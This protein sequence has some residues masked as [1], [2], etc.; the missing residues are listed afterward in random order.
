MTNLNRRISII[1]R[2]PSGWHVEQL[3]SAAE[4]RNIDCELTNLDPNQPLADQIKSLGDVIIY[5]ASSLDLFSERASVL[6]YLRG[7]YMINEGTFTAPY[8]PY[9]Y[10]QQNVLAGTSYTEEYSIP[11]YRAHTK[12]ALE[13]YVSDQSLKLPFIAK[14]NKGAQGKGIE[15]IRTSEDL[16]TFIT[17]QEVSDYVY[18]NFIRND[19]DWRIIV[20]GGR[21]LG[22]VKR[23]PQKEDVF[24]NNLS[25][26]ALATNETDPEALEQINKIAVKAASAMNLRYCGVD[27]I[28]DLDTGKYYVLETNTAP[29]WAVPQE[30]G[31]YFQD[32]TGVDVAEE[33]ID[34]SINFLDRANTSAHQL[35]EDYYK[36]GIGFDSE[37]TFHFASRM[38][39]WSNDEWAR[40]AL[41]DARQQ[42]IGTSGEETGS[43]IDEMVQKFNTGGMTLSNSKKF[44]E[45]HFNKFPRIPLYNRLFFKMMFADSIYSTDIRPQIRKHITDEELL[46]TFRQLRADHDAIRVLS[47]HAINFFYLLKYYFRDNTDMLEKIQI[48]PDEFIAISRE[49]NDELDKYTAQK[50]RI[51]LLTHVIIGESQF[52][53]RR[54]ADEKYAPIIRELEQII[55][56]DFSGTSL[57]NKNEFLVC[58]KI[59]G[60]ET[61]LESIIL[62]ESA[63]SLS[64]AGNF[65]VESNDWGDKNILHSLS[66]AEHRNVLFIMANKDFKA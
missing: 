34:Y 62:D 28:R 24:L 5:R 7:K 31:T 12:E 17:E 55:R 54:L 32:A 61:S 60:V 8:T 1:S 11:T 36:H 26:G 6:P 56:D 21:P 47:T 13:A 57:D 51:Y 16:Q 49:Y 48:N 9:K 3:K 29:Q 66:Q 22:V 14:P 40:Q 20:V 45:Q 64:W 39:L 33:L 59:C 30:A 15:L 41:D 43:K 27:V 35:V 2:D 38:W 42:Y 58:A 46:E 52:Y 10:F 18:Q 4:R 23:T 37:A 19:G 63:N 44:R 50:M 65:I 25:Q 53:Q